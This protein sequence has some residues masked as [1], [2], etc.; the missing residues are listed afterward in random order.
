MK[1]V[2]QRVTTASCTVDNK[3]ISSIQSGFLLFVGFTHTDTIEDVLY[4]A[5]KVAHL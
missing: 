1:V 3:L 5:K 2:V 4:L